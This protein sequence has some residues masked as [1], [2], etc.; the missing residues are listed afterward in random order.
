MLKNIAAF[1][2]N[3]EEHDNRFLR[4]QALGFI[5]EMSKLLEHQDRNAKN[6]NLEQINLHVGNIRAMVPRV[7]ESEKSQKIKQ[8]LALN[9]KR[10][11]DSMLGENGLV[12]RVV[13]IIEEG[14]A[15]NAKTHEYWLRGWDL[16]MHMK[17]DFYCQ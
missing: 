4:E 10:L 8:Q 11:V 6:L 14:S 15:N 2:H 9:S 12:V 7:D 5:A 16:I 17:Y 1:S 3:L 13:P